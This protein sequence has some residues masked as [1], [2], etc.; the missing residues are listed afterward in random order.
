MYSDTIINMLILFTAGNTGIFRPLM[1][2][3]KFT[4]A[5]L[6]RNQVERLQVSPI[7][8]LGLRNN[9]CGRKGDAQPK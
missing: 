1:A 5:K 3:H 6:S 7:S 4:H 2:Q 9:V 8:P